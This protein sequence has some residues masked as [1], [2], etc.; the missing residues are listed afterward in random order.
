MEVSHTGIFRPTDSLDSA[1]L[2]GILC[3]RAKL[4]WQDRSIHTIEDTVAPHTAPADDHGDTAATATT[5]S[6][7]EAVQSAIND[8]FDFDYFRF[9]AQEGRKYKTTVTNG[10][11]LRFIL[12]L[13]D[14]VS[15]VHYGD[16]SIG[17]E[18][19]GRS[20]VSEWIASRSGH[21]YLAVDNVYGGTGNYTLAFAQVDE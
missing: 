17:D 18:L 12:Y 19:R 21:Y 6:V 15:P 10:E 3:G 9:E 2:R 1:E 5:V 16:F 7:G 11:F 13:P 8:E 14:G 20:R 4:R